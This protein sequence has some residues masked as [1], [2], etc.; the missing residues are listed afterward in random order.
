[1]R[2]I[3]R[4][5]LAVAAGLVIGSLVNMGLIL[6]S[7]HVIPPPAGADVTTTEGLKASLH[8][9]EPRHFIFPFLAHGLGTFV[10]ALVATVLT[11][12]R[13]SGPAYVVGCAFLLGGI[14]NVLMLPAPPWFS[15]LDLVVAYL[16]AAWLGHRVAS[17]VL[18]R[19]QGMGVAPSAT[20]RTDG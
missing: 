4:L 9:F 10:G 5:V 20:E 15:V 16:P 13:T 17:R 18:P 6:A 7:G 14:I 2:R 3:L 1:M 12:G 8:L 11:P 19:P